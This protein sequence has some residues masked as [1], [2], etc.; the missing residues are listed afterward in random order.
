MEVYVGFR[1]IPMGWFGAAVQEIVRLLVLRIERASACG[2]LFPGSPLPTGEPTSVTL[3][4]DCNFIRKVAVGD[5]TEGNEHKRSLQDSSR[6]C[7]AGLDATLT[8]LLFVCLWGFAAGFR[9]PLYSACQ[10]V[11]RV[12]YEHEEGA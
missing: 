3:L 8:S 7:Q 5:L 6:C 2:E 10:L 11:Y 9:L 12:P 4:D 1:A